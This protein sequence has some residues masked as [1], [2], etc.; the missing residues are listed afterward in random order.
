MTGKFELISIPKT[1]AAPIKPR[2]TPIYCLKEIFSFKKGPARILV[3]IGCSVTIKAAIP[4]GIPFDIEKN[5]PPKY[6]P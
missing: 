4:V 2:K 5:T 3:N 1:K 6:K